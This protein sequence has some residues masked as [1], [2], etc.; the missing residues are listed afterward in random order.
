M[1]DY[2]L[3]PQNEKIP[4]G[5]HTNI[6]QD[7]E[8]TLQII[9]QSVQRSLYPS[10]KIVLFPS[11]R[12]AIYSICELMEL[13]RSDFVGISE[14]SS[15][16]VIDAIG[17]LAMP[18]CVLS[19][20]LQ[21]ILVNHQ[22]GYRKQLS[23][24]FNGRVI[25]D[26][27]DSLI[28]DERQ[29]LKNNSNYEVFS[30][31]KILGTSF[32]GVVVCRNHEFASRLKGIRDSRDINIGK[33]QYGL[34]N[35]YIRVRD[36]NYLTYYSAVEAMNGFLPMPALAQI[37]KFYDKFFDIANQR[38]S[39]VTKFFQCME[40]EELVFSS[41]YLGEGRLPPAIPVRYNHHIV[42]AFAKYGFK[43]YIRNFNDT[44]FNDQSNFV[45]CIPIPIHQDVTND[46]FDR[47]L[48]ILTSY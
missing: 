1:R 4:E 35:K 36:H 29:L 21:C 26:S 16:C 39:R 43:T 42:K 30:L 37:K 18:E 34:K 28:T 6:W 41:C 12:S 14:Y 15:H 31:P 22:W 19:S 44:L 10:Y 46:D 17:R 38:Q 3:W 2:F 20:K 11:C 9:E 27:C 7:T 23:R 45:P 24:V 25:E 32:G 40:R 33:I 13:K 5:E 48:E 8:E 47:M